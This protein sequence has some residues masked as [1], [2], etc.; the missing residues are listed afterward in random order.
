MKTNSL[1]IPILAHFAQNS[2]AILITNYAEKVS[3]IKLIIREDEIAYWIAIPAL[4]ILY[5]VI[6][7]LIKL[8]PISRENNE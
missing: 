2:L 8:N 5:L 4:I 7:G 6:K 1:F 3:F